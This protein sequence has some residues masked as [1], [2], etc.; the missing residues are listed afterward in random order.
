MTV[1]T[2]VLIPVI[3]DTAEKSF[4]LVKTVPEGKIVF[5]DKNKYVEIHKNAKKNVL[6]GRKKFLLK[7]IWK[8]F[9]AKKNWKKF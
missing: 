2:L 6:F 3:F 4:I 8:R 1:G 5:L 9:Y 7:M